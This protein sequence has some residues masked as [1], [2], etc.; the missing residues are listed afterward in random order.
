[1]ALGYVSLPTLPSASSSSGTC[2]CVQ[3]Q[4]VESTAREQGRRSPRGAAPSSWLL[5]H[6]PAHTFPSHLHAALGASTFTNSPGGPGSPMGPSGPGGPGSPRGPRGPGI[7][8]EPG[9]PWGTE[10]FHQLRL[11][12][13]LGMLPETPLHPYSHTYRHA[14]LPFLAW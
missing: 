1:M 7:P 11:W 10:V 13:G 12:A 8:G 5:P 2:I 9:L 14:W 6:P 4:L 3:A